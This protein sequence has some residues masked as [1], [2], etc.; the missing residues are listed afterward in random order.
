MALQVCI[1]TARITDSVN[2]KYDLGFYVIENHQILDQ[3]IC[4]KKGNSH[5][6]H[7]SGNQLVNKGRLKYIDF[8]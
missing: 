7:S 3:I 6:G 8:V 1:L 4:L 2:P 5:E